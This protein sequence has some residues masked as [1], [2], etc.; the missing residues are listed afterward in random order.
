NAAGI[1]SDDFIM[2]RTRRDRELIV[3]VADKTLGPRATPLREMQ[4]AWKRALL[5]NVEQ[6]GLDGVAS[7]SPR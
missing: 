4:R 2:L 3:E 1:N 5:L 7:D 6:R